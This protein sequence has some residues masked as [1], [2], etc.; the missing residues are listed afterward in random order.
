[1]Y[2]TNYLVNDDTVRL[3][4]SNGILLYPIHRK[5]SKYYVINNY[6]LINNLLT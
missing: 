3:Q 1:M 2:D 5:S 6:Y 4:T